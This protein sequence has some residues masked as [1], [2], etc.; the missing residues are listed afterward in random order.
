MDEIGLK[1][2]TIYIQTQY[3]G[4]FKPMKSFIS[5][6]VLTSLAENGFSLDGIW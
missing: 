4:G 1:R 3:H 2:D 5:L 6:E